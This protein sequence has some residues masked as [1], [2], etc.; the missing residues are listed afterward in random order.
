MRTVRSRGGGVCPGGVSAQG[1]VVCLPGGVC[2]WLR[3]TPPVNRI[4]DR[5]KNITFP[6]LLWRIPDP[7]LPDLTQYNL[8]SHQL[9]QWRIQDFPEEGAPAYNFAKI[10]QKLHE[11]ERIWNLGV[12]SFLPL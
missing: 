9:N 6:Q 12:A 2:L 7:I 4:T 8:I 10:S 1:G 5:C 3:Q 11:I